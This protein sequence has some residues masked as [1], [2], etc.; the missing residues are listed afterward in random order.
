MRIGIPA[1]LLPGLPLLGQDLVPSG[2]H[3]L[4]VYIQP[5]TPKFADGALTY[6]VI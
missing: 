4:L 3:M 2:A 5:Q 1:T 6:D